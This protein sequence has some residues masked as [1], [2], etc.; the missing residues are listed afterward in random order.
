MRLLLFA[1]SLALAACA[2]MRTESPARGAELAQAH[3]AMCHAVG[4]TGASPAPEAPPFRDLETRYRVADLPALVSGAAPGLHPPMA[5]LHL[6]GR[7]AEALGAY[8]RTV[9]MRAPPR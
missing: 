8:L 7:D 6:N 5:G 2:S 3:C 1:A 4:P 9:Q